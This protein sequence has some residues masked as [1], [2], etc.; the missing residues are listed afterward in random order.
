MSKQQTVVSLATN[1]NIIDDAPIPLL[2][3]RL[4]SMRYAPL[5]YQKCAS[6][7]PEKRLFS[8]RKEA[9][10]FLDVSCILCFC[11]IFSQ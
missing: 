1:A 8:H 10:F 4:F 2:E 7:L 5:F 9:L 6:F 3:K 11:P